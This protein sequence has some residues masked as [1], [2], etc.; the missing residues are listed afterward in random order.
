[1]L[2]KT[3]HSS[4]LQCIRQMEEPASFW[5]TKIH[6]SLFTF[7][8]LCACLECSWDHHGYSTFEVILS[9]S[10]LNNVVIYIFGCTKIK[11][12]TRQQNLRRK[13]GRGGSSFQNRYW[14]TYNGRDRKA[15]ILIS[16]P[17]SIHHSIRS[18]MDLNNSLNYSG[19][20][21]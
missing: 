16:R 1:M 2:A 11:A 4:L 21:R 6:N 14:E 3:V 9:R 18:S 12:T 7:V 5:R 13:K 10:K 8:N 17:S 19:E 15:G 20:N